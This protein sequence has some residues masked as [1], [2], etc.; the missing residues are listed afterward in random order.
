MKKGKEQV[1][2]FY[3][4]KKRNRA[5]ARRCNGGK[6]RSEGKGGKEATLIRGNMLWVR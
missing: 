2:T 4:A 5:C 6:K 1:F 3:Y